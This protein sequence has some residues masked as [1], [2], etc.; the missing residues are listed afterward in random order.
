MRQLC[1]NSAALLDCT[2][3][4]TREIAGISIEDNRITRIAEQGQQFTVPADAQ[5]VDCTELTLL[6]GLMDLHSHMGV[7]SMNTAMP[8]SPAM[9]AAMLFHN[10]EACLSAGYTTAR[11]VGG[12]DGA[13]GS[14]IDAGYIKGPRLYPSGPALSQSA[15]HGDRD[16]PWHQH[17]H[18]DNSI[19]GLAQLSLVCD[20][21]DEVRR[22]TRTAFRLGA[23]QIKV[24]ISGGDVTTTQFTVEE[25]RA[26]VTEAR[27]RGTYVTGHAVNSASIML[28]LDAG[29]ECF[30]HGFDLDERTATA[31]RD[32]GA[33]L[34]ATLTILHLMSSDPQSMG[35]PPAAA[36][37]FA[38]I[39]QAAKT[40]LLVARDAGVRIG[41]GTDILGPVQSRRGLEIP[42][43]AEIIGAMAALISATK[44]NAEI[45]GRSED[46]G[47]VEVGKL[48]DLIG[49]SGDPLAEPELFGDPD[50]VELVIKDGVVV[51]DL[52]GR[53]NE[54]F[55]A[56]LNA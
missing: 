27:A 31:M 3:Q 17:H 50:R 33:S 20:G 7:L 25:L 23:T 15:G 53:A 44:T 28:G 24:C 5:E 56:K 26:A 14:V 21:P 2:G 47:T 19:P 34:V 22:G 32:A 36:A 11:E 35:L 8:I 48:A 39:V 41:S 52:R 51:K 10:A 9:T 49:V 6:P 46:L 55:K 54:V 42:L 1:L 38:P 13:L 30:E 4:D 40:S 16:N 37:R 12:A 43:K 29:M 45:I 18:S